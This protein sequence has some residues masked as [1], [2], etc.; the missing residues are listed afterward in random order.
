MTWQVLSGQPL[1]GARRNSTRIRRGA[2]TG[3]DDQVPLRN[4]ERQ[5][6]GLVG[7]QP[8]YLDHQGG[9]GEPARKPRPLPDARRVAAAVVW[10]CRPDGWCDYL[11][12]QWVE[13]TGRPAQEQLGLR[14]GGHL[15]PDDRA[16]TQAAWA[17]GDRA[18]RSVHTEFSDPALRT[19]C[20]DR[21]KIARFP[22]RTF[23]VDRAG[24]GSNTDIEEYKQAGPGSRPNWSG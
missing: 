16:P 10:D 24:F 5:I 23:G 15:H 17:R 6:I 14:L 18:R 7:I 3:F 12:R 8:R 1:F 19:A 13:Y 2:N 11:S 4:R 21:F 20:I 9:A 22:R